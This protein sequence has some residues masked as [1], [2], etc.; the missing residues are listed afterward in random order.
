MRKT[1]G[2]KAAREKKMEI[3]DAIRMLAHEKGIDEN[4]MIETVEH[5]LLSA[6]KKNTAS[7]KDVPLNCKAKIEIDTGEIKIEASK[8]IVEQVNDPRD[9]ITLEEAQKLRENYWQIGDIIK[10]DVTP[11]SFLRTAA[12]TAKQVITQKLRETENGRITQEY[13]E[14]E[15]DILTAVVKFSD[16][17][18]VQVEL[19]DTDGYMDI[20]EC[21]PGEKFNVDD[22]IKVYLLSVNR[23]GTQNQ[24]RSPLI[25]VS[26]I[27]A[28]LI[29]RLFEN[30]VPE[31][32]TGVVQIKSI[33]REAGSRTK[34][35]V[36]SKEP[37]IDPVG[38]CVGPRGA[39]VD[40]VVQE[41][42]G[43]K[44]DIVKWS[45]NPAEFIANSLNPAHVLSVFINED[46]KACRVIVPDNQL[47][48]AIGKEGQNA[49][50]AAKLTSWRID[51][52]SQS[53]AVEMD[54]ME[55]EILTQFEKHANEEP[56]YDYT[57][58]QFVMDVNEAPSIDIDEDETL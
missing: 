57:N 28:G 50:L 17:R 54:D 5:A 38:A 7:E 39:R 26:R 31:I 21:I 4:E 33:A 25:K 15:N 42:R 22:H 58:T 43:E 56:V 14:K 35:A 23:V 12:Q 19:G 3:V 46:E 18:G 32:A 10:V 29:K 36:Y 20:N 41:I 16:S 27:N 1:R 53:Q 49:R 9:Q 44:I 37:A 40:S 11:K 48:L 55:G 45:E 6:F 47:S 34:I 8:T 13:T 51:I 2:S 52:K 24:N 30:E